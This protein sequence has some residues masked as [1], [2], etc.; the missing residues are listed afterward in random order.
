MKLLKSS[1]LLFS[2][3]L[4]TFALADFV[5][6]ATVRVNDSII[7]KLTRN[8]VQPYLICLS[9]FSVGDTL[10]IDIWTDSWSENNCD[11]IYKN[12]EN[13]TTDTL[14]RKQDYIITEDLLNSEF[15]I[16]VVYYSF[17]REPTPW[18]ICKIVPDNKIELIYSQ[19]NEFT[20]L[21]KSNSSDYS[22][23]IDTAVSINFAVKNSDHKVQRSLITQTFVDE[24]QLQKILV[25]TKAEIDY[26]LKFKSTDHVS[27]VQYD[28]ETK[29]HANL[30]L[31]EPELSK[32]KLSLGNFDEYIQYY[33]EFSEGH[34]ILLRAEL[35]VKK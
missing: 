17:S 16:S 22:E 3:F 29:V 21:L 13:G 12:L 23:F 25:S 5:D 10:N 11:V 7:R 2:L 8:Q 18:N 15:L 1:I 20:N 34:L 32:I 9:N 24:Q 33:F 26:L 31:D 35:V 19:L 27:H 28:Y 14:K 6:I 4:S 30:W